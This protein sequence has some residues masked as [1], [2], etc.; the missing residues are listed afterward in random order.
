M[1]TYT[2]ICSH[3]EKSWGFLLNACETINK[4]KDPRCGKWLSPRVQTIFHL[5]KN[6]LSTIFIVIIP[7]HRSRK[8]KKKKREGKNL[9]TFER[10]IKQKLDY[11]FFPSL[12]FFDDFAIILS[13]W[14]KKKKWKGK[15]L[16]EFCF[17][18]QRR[19]EY[20]SL[21]IVYYV[22]H[23]IFDFFYRFCNFLWWLTDREGR[24]KKKKNLWEYDSAVK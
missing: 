7:F 4:K 20:K 16:W 22:E 3:Y 17:V 8:G 10:F 15:N 18:K 11:W 9:W 1:C 24:R 2:Y 14:K 23:F 19:L 12:R 13:D 5:R 6:F 21:N